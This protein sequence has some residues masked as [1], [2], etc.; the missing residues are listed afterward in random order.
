VDTKGAPSPGSGAAFNLKRFAEIGSRSM[1]ANWNSPERQLMIAVLGDAIA[2]FQKGPA[3]GRGAAR[4]YREAELWIFSPGP[5]W[6][7]SFDRV[8][9]VLGIDAEYIRSGLRRPIAAK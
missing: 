9:D 6:L 8:C 5:D 3:P 7:F 1:P 4:T 2:C